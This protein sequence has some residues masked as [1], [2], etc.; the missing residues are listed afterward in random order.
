MKMITRLTLGVAVVLTMSIT[1]CSKDDGQVD[2]T[3]DVVGTY[4]GKLTNS[5]T[6][7]DTASITTITYYNDYTVQVHCLGGNLDTTFLLE[8]YPEGDMMKVCTTG[9]DYY[10]EYGKEKPKN[11]HMMGS[12]G[13]MTWG[14]HMNDDHNSGDDHYG[15]FD[16]N[17]NE[18]DYTINIENTSDNS[19]ERFVGR[20]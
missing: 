3:K 1:A 2:L 12:G 16:T 20:K 15:D 11:D 8:L 6:N 17:N 9:D 19:S 18:F 7:T 13:M 5:V 10:K 14:D 4:Q